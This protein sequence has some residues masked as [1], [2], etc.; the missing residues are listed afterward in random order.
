MLQRYQKK[1]HTYQSVADLF[2]GLTIA[3]LLILL[4]I[5]IEALNEAIQIRK[6]KNLQK[7]FE[8]AFSEEI[9]RNSN[10]IEINTEKGEIVMKTQGAFEI[11]VWV[12]NPQNEILKSFLNTRHSLANILD[13]IE[14]NFKKDFAENHLNAK[15]YVEILVV[16]HTDC[17]PFSKNLVDGLKLE[18]NWDL[19]VLRATAIARFFSESCMDGSF[20]CCEDHSQNCGSHNKQKR[21]DPRKWKL[22]PAGRGEYEPTQTQK[23]LEKINKKECPF[24]EKDWMALQ[25]RVSIQIVLRTDKLL[26]QNMKN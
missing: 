2:S 15:D 14:E 7:M 1:D 5:W 22:L 6:L 12:F 9:D 3:I 21:I 20:T 25:R 8:T 23:L 16:G 4:V 11:G 18:D 19:S 24:Q 13:K 17:I 10:D 26:I